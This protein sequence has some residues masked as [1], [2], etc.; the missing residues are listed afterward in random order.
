MLQPDANR[1]WFTF[2]VEGE[3]NELAVF[4]FTGEEERNRP[5]C[6]S[7][8]VASLSANL[9]INDLLGK[10]ALLTIHD[11]SG[12]KRLVHGSILRMWQLHTANQRTHYR[13]ELVPVFHFLDL[14][15][16]HRIYQKLTVEEIITSVLKKHGFTTEQ[17]AFFL[18]GKY[19]PREYC[20]QYMES[21]LYFISRLCEEE[22]IHFFFE[23]EESLER[24][25]FADTH[26]GRD[27]PGESALRFFPGSGQPADTAVIARVQLRH[28][29]NSDKATYREWNF[30]RPTVDITGQ[31]EEDDAQKAPIPPRAHLEMY[32]FPHLYQT[33][34]GADRYAVLQLF[35]QLTFRE[36]IEA[37]SDVSRF[38]PGFTFNMHSHPRADANR[39][40]AVISVRHQGEQPQALRH[41]SPDDRG[42]LYSSSVVAIPA[43]TRFI[44]EI[45]HPKK[46]IEG[47]QSAIVTGPA[48]EE[49]YT[50]AYGRV[51][52]QFHWDRLGK[53]D[54]NTT[55]WVRVADRH[56]GENF[57][58]VQIP[59]IG[60]E[61][62]VE[63]MEG[64]PDRPVI[65]GRVY[66]SLTKPPWE[67]PA[68]KTLS[69]IQS[70]E[71]KAARRN[72]LLFDDSEGQIQTQVSSD[73]SLS[74]LNLGYI[75]RIEHISGRKDFRGEG[76]ELRTDDWGAVRAA[77]GLFISTDKREKAEEHHKDMKEAVAAVRKAVDDH[78]ARVE[79]AKQ[80][81]ALD[82][83]TDGDPVA[84]TLDIQ[85]DEL[86][87][88]GMRHEELSTPHILVSSA[89]GASFTATQ[90][91][92]IATTNDT[93][94]TTDKHFSVS[95]AKNFAVSAMEKVRLFA[96]N[97]GMRF[98]AAKGPV[99]I[100]AQ[101]DTLDAIAEKVASIISARGGIRVSAPK[102]IELNAAGSFIRIGPNGIEHGTKGR[103]TVYAASHNHLGPRRKDYLK[104]VMPKVDG[105]VKMPP[106]MLKF[107]MQHAPEQ[108][109]LR[110]EKYTVYCNGGEYDTGYTDENG[111]FS[112]EHDPAQTEYEIEM[113][114]NHRF[115][116]KIAETVS[117]GREGLK[118]R[119][120][121][122]GFRSF[123][124]SDKLSDEDYIFAAWE[125]LY[126]DDPDDEGGGSA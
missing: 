93:A 32:Q 104:P 2:S 8:E 90:S 53:K 48:G 47:L 84:H 30:T 123:V 106:N 94:I 119:V 103:F 20:V 44:P 64:D 108:G 72:Q 61:V 83:D 42:F 9:N 118:E 51:K 14:N 57:G 107:T 62:M 97:K 109:V 3:V 115:V 117:E 85:A 28:R 79:G 6:F 41:E 54:E 81:Q 101:S 120:Q 76:Y 46:R 92:H 29:V 63:Y 34:E 25:C 39:R 49:V 4:S 125:N 77:R 36:W 89:T 111:Q 91:T 60:Q 102:Y 113:V 65:T 56:A 1:A 124:D 22:G 40:W 67:L 37:E 74:Q 31:V 12:G 78:T 105:E 7:I 122:D 110:N 45:R 99:K 70:R 68:Q 50:D 112:F 38:L 26:G 114:D 13:C 95:A 27:I 75:T 23:H 5:Y 69:G 52:V 15:N 58:F 19:S 35:R 59:R 55:C 21:D 43:E 16:D 100:Q 24:I 80:H 82:G 71:F 88:P 86:R 17:Y 96:H 66:K 121:R 73:H 33:M 11:R 87:G 10:K 116:V 18:Q 126:G 98:M